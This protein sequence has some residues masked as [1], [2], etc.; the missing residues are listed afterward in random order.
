MHK[1]ILVAGADFPL[2]NDAY[3]RSPTRAHIHLE[4]PNDIIAIRKMAA[5]VFR[6][7]VYKYAQRSNQDCE[8]HTHT[9]YQSTH[10][11]TKENRFYLSARKHSHMLAHTYISHDTAAR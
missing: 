5:R 7:N 6:E 10:T 11:H 4:K 2:K 9:H 8:P 3:A 1:K